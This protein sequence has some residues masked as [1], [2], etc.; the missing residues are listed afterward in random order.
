MSEIGENLQHLNVAWRHF[1][2]TATFDKTLL[3]NIRLAPIVMPQS[4]EIAVTHLTMM[5]LGERIKE[6]KYPLNWVQAFRERWLPQFILRRWPVKYHIWKVDLLYPEV[7]SEKKLH[8]Q[9][10]LY[11]NI[12]SA[13]YPHFEDTRMEQSEED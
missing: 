12:K 8:P 10:A 4:M 13:G 5:V 2:T 1:Y 7:D 11:S 6:I 9:L 3:K